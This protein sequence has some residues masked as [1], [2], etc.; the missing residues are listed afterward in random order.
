MAD[1][2]SDWIETLRYD[3]TGNLAACSCAVLM[4]VKYY[5]GRKDMK[6]SQSASVARPCLILYRNTDK[7]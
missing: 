6:L 4:H 3:N 2:L 5:L 7:L 1:V